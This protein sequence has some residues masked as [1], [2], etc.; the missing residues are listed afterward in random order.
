MEK[1]LKGFGIN[2][3]VLGRFLDNL[4]KNNYAEL[5]YSTVC[6]EDK[7]NEIN[8]EINSMTHY[9]SFIEDG[10]IKVSKMSY[11]KTGKGLFLRLG[12]IS[13]DEKSYNFITKKYEE[14]VSVFGLKGNTPILENLQQIDSF[15]G[16]YTLPSF[17]VSGDVVG[18]GFDGEPIL[19]N[20]KYIKKIIP[21]FKS[22]TEKY[23]N[24]FYQKAEV[25]DYEAKEIY[26]TS[27]G[28]FYNNKKYTNPV[29]DFDTRRG[30]K[31]T[32]NLHTVIINKKFI[33]E[34]FS[35]AYRVEIQKGE[36][37]GLRFIVNKSE[38]DTD[39]HIITT[40]S[41]EAVIHAL[42]TDNSSDTVE[43]KGTAITSEVF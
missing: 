6:D 11:S 1:L 20:V 22:I 2:K 8:K 39:T 35:D 16:R 43:I 34:V 5:S 12:I 40:I 36:F 24:K 9:A 15:S 18:T 29:K 27:E 37:R 41:D 4:D 26:E 33:T 32:E 17:I 31:R 23:L 21:N 19:K 28:L 25:A 10:K 30:F 7:M 14:G 38:L 42:R 13:K 3:F